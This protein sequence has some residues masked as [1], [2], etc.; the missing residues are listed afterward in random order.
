ML[1]WSYDDIFEEQRRPH[2]LV[3]LGLHLVALAVTY[4][5]IGILVVDDA[6]AL[7]AAITATVIIIGS[8][9]GVHEAASRALAH[10]VAPMPEHELRERLRAASDALS[11]KYT[12]QSSEQAA[13]ECLPMTFT[14]EYPNW[15]T[16]RC[17]G[18]LRAHNDADPA[19]PK[20]GR[21]FTDLVFAG[22]SRST[23]AATAVRLKRNGLTAVLSKPSSHALFKA[24]SEA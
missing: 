7:G 5:V 19:I 3:N 20:Y 15:L 16:W 13:P 18:T 23:I 2:S 4:L 24:L 11:V 12:M 6:V 14:L 1:I 22:C 17:K 8:A 9:Y 10:R 21:E